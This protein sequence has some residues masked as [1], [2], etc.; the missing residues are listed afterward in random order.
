MKVH[1]RGRYISGLTVF[2]ALLLNVQIAYGECGPGAGE[3]N[4]GTGGDGGGGGG[5]GAG[6]VSAGETGGPSSGR[7]SSSRSNSDNSDGRCESQVGS[8]K[9]RNCSEFRRLSTAAPAEYTFAQAWAGISSL[10]GGEENLLPATNSVV[11]LAKSPASS[12]VV[13]E[14]KRND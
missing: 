6:G 7:Q 11:M 3:T 1:L 4:D 2:V 5:G 8:I 12:V 14:G 10:F 9:G 13:G